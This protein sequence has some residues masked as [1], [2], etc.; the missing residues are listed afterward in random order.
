[1]QK[2]AKFAKIQPVNK[3]PS[4]FSE[5]NICISYCILRLILFMHI[6]QKGH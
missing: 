1:M 6:L 5:R 2:N 3:T 4:L